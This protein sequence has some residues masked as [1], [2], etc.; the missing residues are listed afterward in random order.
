MFIAATRRPHWSQWADRS[1]LV[2]AGAGPP[3]SWRDPMNRSVF[4][5]ALRASAKVALGA[6]VAGCGGMVGSTAEHAAT[7]AS[8]SDASPVTD[9]TSVDAAAGA[10]DPPSASSVLPEGLHA[11]AAAGISASAFDCCVA[12]LEAVPPDDGVRS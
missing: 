1:M 5:A 3:L 12:L 6:A 2:L 4:R 8:T 9:A 7:E 11:D 10:C